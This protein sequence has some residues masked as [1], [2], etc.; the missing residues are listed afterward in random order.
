MRFVFAIIVFLIC[1]ETIAQDARPNVLLIVADD[2][3]YDS[4][5]FAGGVAPDVTPNL[6]R[7]ASESFSFKNAFSVVSVCQPSRQS[8]LSGLI[9][10]HYGSKGFFPMA[11]G[12]P[13]LPGL[14]RASGYVTGNIHKWGHMRPIESFNWNYDNK[15]LG[16]TDPTGI[17]GRDPQAMGRGFRKLIEI[18]EEND[19]PFFMIVNS[20]DPHRPFH[21]DYKSN[22]GPKP[23]EPSR[24]YTAEEI[25]V[26]PTLPDIPGI[27][28]DLAKYA[29]SV[30]RLDDTVGECLKVLRESNKKSSTIVIFVSDNGMPLPFGKFDAYLSS[31]RSPFLMRWPEG[32]STPGVDHDHL[33]S[34]MDITPTVLE[35]AGVPVPTPMDGKSLVPL[36]KKNKNATWRE[37]ITFI[38]NEDINYTSSYKRRAKKDPLF[39][40]KMIAS[41]WELRPDHPS[42]GTYSRS[43]EIRTYFDGRYGYIYNDCYRENGLELNELGAIV[44]YDGASIIAMR[45]MSQDD[46]AVKER[47]EFFLLRAKEE[48]YD[49]ST[50]PG[51]RQN[52]ALDPNYAVVLKKSRKGLAKWMKSS[53]DPLLEEYQ[54]LIN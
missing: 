30:R 50:D 47:Y 15:A 36:L 9:P 52:L 11:D 49:W 7:L 35:L 14:L 10:Q 22:G 42:K 45:K 4:P 37:S 28:E 2:L 21:G 44:P 23:K 20:A 13:T 41:G 3:G 6:D 38:R 46:P 27:R 24:I 54:Y 12:T 51:S 16:L 18:A 1:V 29:S 26:P 8:M 39:M 32:I 34:L 43:K 5:G 53:K 48:L 40:D 17:V 33:V 31:N 19:Q 25:T